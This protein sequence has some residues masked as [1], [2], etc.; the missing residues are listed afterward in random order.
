MFLDALKPLTNFS[1][2]VIDIIF[3][4]GVFPKFWKFGS[5]SKVLLYI[6]IY[7]YVCVYIYICVRACVRACVQRNTK[8]KIVKKEIKEKCVH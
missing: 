3:L 4:I 2:S 1:S 5:F 7:I 6:Y 8:E